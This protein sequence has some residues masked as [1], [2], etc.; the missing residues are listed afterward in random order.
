M[1]ADPDP[2]ATSGSPV[3][4][5]RADR[6]NAYGAK[7]RAATAILFAI[8]LGLALAVLVTYYLI[9]TVASG[10]LSD[11]AEDEL[12]VGRL[13]TGI[14]PWVQELQGTVDFAALATAVAG[15]ATLGVAL[16]IAVSITPTEADRSVAGIAR[17]LFVDRVTFVTL[18]GT[19]ATCL[20]AIPF[21]DRS[22]GEFPT[23]TVVLIGLALA[24]SAMA[25]A[26]RPHTV[27]YLLDL[28]RS[29]QRRSN[30]QRWQDAAQDPVESRRTWVATAFWGVL[31]GVACGFLLLWTVGAPPLFVSG[32][33][34]GVAATWSAAHLIASMRAAAI[35]RG[36]TAGAIVSPVG[37]GVLLAWL[38]GLAYLTFS[39]LADST[40]LALVLAAVLCAGPMI[41]WRVGNRLPATSALSLRPLVTRYVAARISVLDE[42]IKARA[43]EVDDD[44]VVQP[45]NAGNERTTSD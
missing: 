27:Q 28:D 20:S 44:Q 12:P 38:F 21:L 29:G 17:L 31:I 7:L 23:G 25:A 43:D 14:W 3:D 34:W 18:I 41:A 36:K 1:P 37:M 2:A 15:V 19:A 42:Q 8:S 45:S 24:M 9:D 5:A 10:A 11:A 35:E 30:L 26:G 13:L 6:I 40:V 32:L 16:F 22:S 4:A 33:I 39:T